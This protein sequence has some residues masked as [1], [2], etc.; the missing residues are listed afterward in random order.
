MTTR[1]LIVWGAGAGIRLPSA[2][3]E[4]QLLE[5]QFP[6]ERFPIGIAKAPLNRIDQRSNEVGGL[7]AQERASDRPS[8]TANE[9][10]NEKRNDD[11]S[12]RMS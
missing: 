4:H 8:Q 12:R 3:D 9:G 2:V 5:H 10:A 7:G 11:T 6:A 1:S